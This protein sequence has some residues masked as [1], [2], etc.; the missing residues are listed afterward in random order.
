MMLQLTCLLYAAPKCRSSVLENIILPPGCLAQPNSDICLQVLEWLVNK[1]QKDILLGLHQH[2]N[3]MMPSGGGDRLGKVPRVTPHT[4]DKQV[5]SFKGHSDAIF[6]SNGILQQALAVTQTL[7]SPRYA[8]L[9][10]VVS[11][12]KV[13]LQNLGSNKTGIG[14]L[15]QMMQ[16]VKTHRERNLSL[17]DIFGLLIHLFSLAGTDVQ[18]PAV[19][20]SHLLSALKQAMYEDRNQLQGSLS[21]LVELKSEEEYEEITAEIFSKLRYIALARKNLVR[22]RSLLSQQ[23][24]S[25]PT[26]Y[27]SLL[28]QLMA[29]VLDPARPELPD[30]TCKSSGLKDILKSGFSLLLNRQKHQHP[31]D[32]PLLI[33]FI[34]GGIT[35]QEVKLIEE[36]VISSGQ[37]TKVL[38]GGTR[39]LSPSDTVEAVFVKD[40]LM[41]DIL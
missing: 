9:D 24:P 32:N 20:Q 25:Q 14:V 1:R 16:L 26:A 8:Q 4:I 15:V 30:L 3:T 33:V 12:E 2:L 41:Q 21:K 34:L 23:G 39:L 36:M 5:A 13:L 10:V 31:L 11:I 7:R 29:D 37:E 6:Q 38:V 35:A 17:T 22:Y 18:F 40:P 27:H 28:H 19:E